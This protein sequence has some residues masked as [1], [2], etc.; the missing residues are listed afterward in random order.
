MI[1]S[2]LPAEQPPAGSDELAAACAARLPRV[3]LLAL[4][5]EVDQMT[6]FSEEFTHAGGA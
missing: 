3:Q 5:I 6:R 1:V 4:L 2:P